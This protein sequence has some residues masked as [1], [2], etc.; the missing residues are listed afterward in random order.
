MVFRPGTLFAGQERSIWVTLRVP[1]DQTVEHDLGTFE[2]AYTKGGERQSL[3]LD[4]TPRVA[5]VVDRDRM[6]AS[7]DTVVWEASV[8]EDAYHR[9]EEDVARAVKAGRPEVA[10]SAIEE[11]RAQSTTLNRELKSEVV[12]QNLATLGAL[13]EE[14][15]DAFTG[16]DQ[17]LKQ[18]KLS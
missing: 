17:E 9:M 5:C 4:G 11:Y 8:V 7:I 16:E 13:E 1:V 3:T 10:A 6:L 14:L 2:L 12:E 18:N 15:A